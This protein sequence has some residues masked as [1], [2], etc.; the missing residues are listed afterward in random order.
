[1]VFAAGAPTAA[2]TGG[3]ANSNS[4]AG[5][6]QPSDRTVETDTVDS[7]TVDVDTMSKIVAFIH[8]MRDAVSV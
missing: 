1:M 5:N 7:D 2:T 3:V 6:R 8:R 4:G